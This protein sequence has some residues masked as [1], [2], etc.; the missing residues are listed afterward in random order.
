M[1]L[2][3]A[4]K[5]DSSYNICAELGK[6]SFVSG[7]KNIINAF[8]TSL[9]TRLRRK[10]ILLKS[11]NLR[12]KCHKSILFFANYPFSDWIFRINNSLKFHLFNFHYASIDIVF[13]LF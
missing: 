2:K 10:N 13:N 3:R 8:K 1:K 6:L 12:L 9:Y 7:N 5:I 11:N 4:R